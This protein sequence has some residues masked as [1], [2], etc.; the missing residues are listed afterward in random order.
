VKIPKGLEMHRRK[1]AS[2]GDTG[3]VE[4]FF[5]NNQGLHRYIYAE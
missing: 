1:L 4:N 2:N 3:D 5:K